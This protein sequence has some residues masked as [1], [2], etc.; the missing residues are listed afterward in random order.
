MTI[1]SKWKNIALVLTIGLTILATSC[2][3]TPEA[4]FVID[5]GSANT[6][7]NEEIQFDASCSKDA[8]SYFWNFGDGTSQTGYL[9]K[10]KYANAGNYTVILT[11]THSSK[12]ATLSKVVSIVN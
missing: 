9:T 10:H 5:N 12:S 2:T 11:A 7:V 3:K 8:D 1:N 6:K 4:C